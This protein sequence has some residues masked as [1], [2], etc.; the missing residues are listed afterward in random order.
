MEKQFN[1]ATVGRFDKGTT[2]DSLFAINGARWREI[3]GEKIAPDRDG[4][5]I[6]TKI[7]TEIRLPLSTLDGISPTEVLNRQLSKF[8]VSFCSRVLLNRA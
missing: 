8:R 4:A 3:F 7:E 2:S 5:G 1:E 6:E